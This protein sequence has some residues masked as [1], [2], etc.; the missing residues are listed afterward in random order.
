MIALKCKIKFKLFE[1]ISISHDGCCLNNNIEH[2]LVL[3]A[4]QFLLSV[5]TKNLQPLNVLCIHEDEH[6][7]SML[8]HVPRRNL[9]GA[10]PLHVYYATDENMA[11][12]F[13]WEDQ[14]FSGHTTHKAPASALPV[15]S[16]PVSLPTQF[17]CL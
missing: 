1:T 12:L 15:V 16:L 4:A 3:W 8:K 7:P 13:Q 14:V 5:W 6:M 9:P 2:E 11:G 17:L 10:H